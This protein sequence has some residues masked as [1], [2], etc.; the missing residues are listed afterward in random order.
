[1]KIGKWFIY[2]VAMALMLV[3]VTVLAGQNLDIWPIADPT[4]KGDR[5]V[6]QLT[7]YY[8]L[9]P[10]ATCELDPTEPAVNLIFFL[11]LYEKGAK[12][13]HIVTYAHPG[14]EV[15]PGTYSPF[16]L[17]ADAYTGAQQQAL[18]DFLDGPV[19]DALNSGRPLDDLYI[20]V[21]LKDV[22]DDYEN[23][24]TPPKGPPYCVS[25]EITIVAE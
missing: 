8:E 12:K 25:A 16:C 13:W 9:I 3:P 15:A 17:E 24:G 20:A 19:L 6:G 4:P 1:M 5:S 14:I 23:I 18:L 22:T 21:L 2:I 10:G 7:V 11:R